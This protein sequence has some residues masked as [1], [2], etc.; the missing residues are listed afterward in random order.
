MSTNQADR[1]IE[2]IRKAADVDAVGVYFTKNPKLQYIGVAGIGRHGGALLFREWDD[3]DVPVRRIVVKYSLH[4]KVDANLRNETQWLERLRGAEHIGQIIPL[5]DAQL[6]VTGTG[7]RPTI[8]LEFIPHG[9]AQDFR[10]KMLGEGL[11]ILQS[12]FLWRILLCLVR[13]VVAMAYPP[14]APAGAPVTRERIL[15]GVEPFAL[16]Q[17]SSH[18]NNLMIDELM[19][20]DDDHGMVPRFKLIDFG[21]G[22][23]EGTFKEAYLDNVWALG[24]M[25]I[26]LAVPGLGYGEMAKAEDDLSTIYEL[27]EPIEGKTKMRTGAHPEFCEIEVMD[28][29]LRDLIVRCMARNSMFVPSMEE[30][31]E[32][33]EQ[34]VKNRKPEDYFN[35]EFSEADKELEM[36]E[37]IR[38][39]V[40]RFILDA[41]VTGGPADVERNRPETLNRTGAGPHAGQMGLTMMGV[42]GRNRAAIVLQEAKNA[43]IRRGKGQGGDGT[44]DDDD[45]D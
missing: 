17:N 28:V 43:L 33:C 9:T 38:L 39:Y 41:D 10:E 35:D 15:P 19:V 30:L 31:L 37:T 22:N 26:A 34:A 23:A 7:K 3:G 11:V 14:E 42:A 16:T 45:V 24:H 25:I 12:Q 27:Q 1:D 32:K 8:A 44:D 5:A 29:T 20:G 2:N 40:Q 36:D 13:Q 18:L 4:A 21:R 6:D